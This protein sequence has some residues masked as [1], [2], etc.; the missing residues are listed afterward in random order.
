MSWLRAHLRESLS[1]YMHIEA[2]HQLGRQPSPL[3]FS[4]LH[5]SSALIIM[6]VGV[7]MKGKRY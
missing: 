5:I 2:A 4:T 1:N 7:L 6:K 3:M